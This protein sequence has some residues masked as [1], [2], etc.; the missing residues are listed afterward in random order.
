MPPRDAA[1][2]LSGTKH[3]PHDIYGKQTLQIFRCLVIDTTPLAQD[4]RI[5][6]KC[7]KAAER[8]VYRGK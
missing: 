8:F 7:R 1:N 4:T 3:C 2:G 5:P 6:D